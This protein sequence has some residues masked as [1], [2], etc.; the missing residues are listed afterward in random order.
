M[1]EAKTILSAEGLSIGFRAKKGASGIAHHINLDLK[2]GTLTALIGA[3]G[4]GKSTLLRTLTGLQKPLA[5]NI[6]LN[7]RDIS[8]YAP[9]ALAQQLS[10][11]LTGGLPPSNLSIYELVALGRQPY[12]NWLDALSPEDH[13]EVN[14][15]MELTQTA[16][17]A[18]KKYYELSDGQ[19][20][21]VLI[22]RALAQN[23][24]LIL[25]D[26]PT[27]HLDLL[28]KAGLLKLLK[29]LS[30][31][32]GKCILYSTHDIDLALQLSDELIVMAEGSIMQ[33][34]PQHLISRNAFNT[35]FRDESIVFDASKGGFTI[36]L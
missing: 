17:L 4:I 12:T 5:G 35:I 18:G 29:K 31:E 21:K 24:P 33:G 32:A 34:T 6:L 14:K 28:H 13:K 3:N 16:H 20:Q 1:G 25:L 27:T 11:V 36:N 23:T 9:H 22:A 10:L 30:A 19:L 8:G 15:A 26:E 7:G 2:A